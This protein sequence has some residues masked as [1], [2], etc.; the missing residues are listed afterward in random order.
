MNILKKFYDYFK[1]KMEMNGWNISNFDPKLVSAYIQDL[2][3][4]S[5][6][7]ET[8]NRVA[9][10]GARGAR[11]DVASAW[12]PCALKYSCTLRVKLIYECID[13]FHLAC[14]TT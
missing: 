13:S 7:R 3:N 6:G 8:V 14:P 10:E 9:A 12:K 4:F 5:I 11:S 2:A 1:R